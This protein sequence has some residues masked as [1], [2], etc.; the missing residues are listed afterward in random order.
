LQELSD[1]GASASDWAAAVSSAVGGKAGGKGPTS[2]GNGT[3]PDKVE[4]AISLASDYL[5]KFK[6]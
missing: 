3:N 5:S 4:E 6:L 1:Q 2:I